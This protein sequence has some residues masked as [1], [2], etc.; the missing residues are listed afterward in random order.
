MKQRR[1]V[2]RTAVYPERSV[3]QASWVLVSMG[4]ATAPWLAELGGYEVGT[5]ELTGPEDIR[6]YRLDARWRVWE[7]NGG[8]EK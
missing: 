5:R 4:S 1:G 6:V 3:I 7:S 8:G 2:E